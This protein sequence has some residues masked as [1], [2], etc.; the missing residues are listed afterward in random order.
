M[1]VLRS[2][3]LGFASRD[4]SPVGEIGQV[5]WKGVSGR[6]RGLQEF[7][8]LA[9]ESRVEI[10]VLGK[11][12]CLIGSLL[13]DQRHAWPA[14]FNDDLFE[15]GRVV[16]IDPAHLAPV[17]GFGREAPR[18]LVFF[19]AA[20]KFG[21]EVVVHCGPFFSFVTLIRKGTQCVVRH[22]SRGACGHLGM[23]RPSGLQ[24]LVLLGSREF[25]QSLGVGVVGAEDAH[26]GGE[27]LGGEGLRLR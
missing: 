17:M 9:L 12:P 15:P 6:D 13:A 14:L 5:A 25:A 22:R 7:E 16:D 27:D 4:Q 1:G 10:G 11:K 8:R 3:H 19:G 24:V 21:G 2:V 20:V 23:R 26:G 18:R